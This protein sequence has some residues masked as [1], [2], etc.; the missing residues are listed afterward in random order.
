MSYYVY[1]QETWDE[2]R[3][4]KEAASAPT[5]SF[6]NKPPKGLVNRSASPYPGP[7]QTVHYNS[8]CIR[9]GEWYQGE[10][11]PLPVIPDTYEFV[12]LVSWGLRIQKKP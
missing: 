11:V 1:P 3:C 6:G 7:G 10:T 8:G 5:D 2:A 4:R 12:P 9:G